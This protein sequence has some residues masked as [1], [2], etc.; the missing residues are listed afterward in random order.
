MVLARERVHPRGLDFANQRKVVHLRDDKLLSWAAIADLVRNRQKRKPSWKLCS[1]T[2]EAFSKPHARRPYRYKNCGRRPWKVSK[3]VETFLVRR[4]LARRVQGICT[5]ALLARDVMDAKHIAL[6]D[7]TI[8]KVL[9]KRGYKWLP[10][11]KKP[12]YSAPERA[13]R[14]EFGQAGLALSDE[15]LRRKVSMCMDGVVL[16]LPPED[17]I[18]RVNHCRASDTH[19]YRKRSERMLPE[20]AGGDAYA[21]QVPIER[22]LPMW[23]GVGPT[24]FA[25]V[26]LHPD[27]KAN[28]EQWVAAVRAGRLVAALRRV[29]QGR[30]NGPWG[31]LCDG[32]KFLHSNPST[33]AHAARSVSLWRL[34]PKSPDLNPV[35][36][37]WSWLRRR[38]R[39]MDLADLR[40]KRAPVTKATFRARVLQVIAT[41]ASDRAAAACYRH[42]RKACQEVVA[43]KG[44]AVR[45]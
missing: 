13:R 21:K 9:A 12:K 26:L 14:V 2:Y 25:A 24:G 18:G 45:G 27:K 6:E 19:V 39:A 4:L 38:L 36:K 44:A 31:V 3:E 34:P 29:N 32:E 11:S 35:E 30:A 22:A 17:D 37:Y 8:R 20:L 10:R 43:R 7:S 1:R 41:K 16:S 42:F 23:G 40:A 28:T 5:A 33:T 15:E